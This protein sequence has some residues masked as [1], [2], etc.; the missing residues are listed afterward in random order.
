M[1]EA[2]AIGSLS[3]SSAVVP[4]YRSAP[5]DERPHWIGPTLGRLLSTMSNLPAFSI[6]EAS[7]SDFAKWH[8][9]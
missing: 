5:Q 6:S 4:D 3:A 7:R 1:V 9:Q 8:W 2:V